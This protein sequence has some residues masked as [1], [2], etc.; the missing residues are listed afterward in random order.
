MAV[1]AAIV[2]TFV[3]LITIIA[4]CIAAGNRAIV[5]EMEQDLHEALQAIELAR[6]VHLRRRASL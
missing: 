4:V 5:E 2:I 1:F 3:M 6:R